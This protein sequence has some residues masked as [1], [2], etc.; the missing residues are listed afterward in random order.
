MSDSLWVSLPNN[1]KVT[2]DEKQ[3]DRLLLSK[4]VLA[5]QSSK[6]RLCITKVC[7]CRVLSFARR[8]RVSCTGLMGGVSLVH[9]LQNHME[10][11]LKRNPY[12]SQIV[13]RSRPKKH[14][15]I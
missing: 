13:K 14:E 8:W 6:V 12:L 7:F 5:D 15:E 9:L 10:A 3:A 11:P 1:Q 4:R 2:S